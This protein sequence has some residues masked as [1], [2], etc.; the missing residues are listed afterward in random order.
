M[1]GFGT[2]YKDAIEPVEEHMR[3]INKEIQAAMA[4]A[5][6][7][8]LKFE[9]RMKELSALASK[10]LAELPDNARKIHNYC[11]DKGWYF[12]CGDLTPR[13]ID[14]I[15]RMIDNKQDEDLEESIRDFARLQVDKILQKVKTDWPHRFHILNDAFEAHKQRLYTLSIPCL[16]AQADGMSY[17]ILGVSFFGKNSGVPK[18]KK[19]LE[20]F[21]EKNGKNVFFTGITDLLLD[22]LRMV[23]SVS[24]NTED[25][26]EKRKQDP[27]YGPLNRH[28][29]LHGADVDY[30]TEPN[31][32][33]TIMIIGYLADVREMLER[34]RKDA[35]EDAD[36]CKH[37]LKN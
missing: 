20:E 2:S 33:R 14:D 31:G 26:N 15:V 23:S 27:S 6:E 28:G 19:A 18:T 3:K 10:A 16:L 34:I 30:A 29:A 17:E 25:R 35:D 4:P 37:L 24:V 32:L 7:H 36:E 8:I 5:I 13:A 11:A 22:P 12:L 21:S 1:R 9:E